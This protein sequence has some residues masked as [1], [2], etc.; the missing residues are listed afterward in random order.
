MGCIFSGDGPRGCESQLVEIDSGK[1]M[2]SFAQQ[3]RRH[4]QMHFVDQASD[5]KLPNDGWAT[6]NADVFAFGRLFRLLESR[7]Q[8]IGDEV[9][10]GAAFHRERRARVMREHKNGSVVR[11][12]IA[13]PSFPGIVF[14]RPGTSNRA[15]HIPAQDPGADIFERLG[16]KIV[17][18][19]GRPAALTVH[20]LECLRLLKP[21]V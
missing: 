8:S 6:A 12:I 20:L 1:Q 5:Q 14:R 19:R 3:D 13:P 16:G 2:F 11:R 9:K 18:D 10:G 17:I 7:L 21:E 4:G 15:E